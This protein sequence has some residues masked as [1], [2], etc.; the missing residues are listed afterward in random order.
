[1]DSITNIEKIENMLKIGTFLKM[2]RINYNG[3]R[4]YVREEPFAYYSGLTGALS[5]ATFRGD[6]DAKRL[7]G[8]R[9][10]MIDSFGQKNTEDFVS[11]TADFGTLL[12][13]SAVT[14]KE[15][16][17]IVRKEE[18]DKA[19]EYFINAYKVKNMKPDMLIINKMVFDYQKHISS[20]MQFVYDRVQEIYAIEAPCIWETARIATPVDLVCLCKATE[21][22]EFK[23]TTLNIKTSSQIS[24]HQMEQISCELNMWNS[25]Y[26]L[27]C[28]NTAIIRTKDWKESSGPTYEFKYLNKDEANKL[29][30]EAA[31]RVLLCLNG[32]A[33]YFPSP[34]SKSFKGTTKIGEKPE[35]VITTLEEEWKQTMEEL[36]EEFIITEQND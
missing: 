36:T 28:E 32:N 34:T 31:S 12:H 18:Q 21:K 19:T 22:G 4:L 20:L 25:T 10:S 6:Q 8:W 16:G 33:S 9:N 2:Y 14:I 23:N 29:F 1:M 3:Y 5:A 26:D 15:K 11:M 30:L 35:I 13:M 7:E 27:Q 17:C 24:A